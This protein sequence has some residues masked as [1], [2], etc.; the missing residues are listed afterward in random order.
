MAVMQKI[1]CSEAHI[2]IRSYLAGVHFA[3]TADLPQQM[4]KQVV[5]RALDEIRPLQRKLYGNTEI[6]QDLKQRLKLNIKSDD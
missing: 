4:L 3:D 2:V 6:K 1:G 5:F